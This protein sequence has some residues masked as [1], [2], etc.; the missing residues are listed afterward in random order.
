MD[1]EILN[2]KKFDGE[3]LSMSKNYKISDMNL[4]TIKVPTIIFKQKEVHKVSKILDDY[5]IS[6]AVTDKV[7]EVSSLMNSKGYS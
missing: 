1:L 2:E 3:T 7:S 6:G 5:I 4:K